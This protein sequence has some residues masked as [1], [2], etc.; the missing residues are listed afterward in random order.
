MTTRSNGL[1]WETLQMKNVVREN[2]NKYRRYK[3]VTVVFMSV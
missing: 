1:V 2:Q 3:N